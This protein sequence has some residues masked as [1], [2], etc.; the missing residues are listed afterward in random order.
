M[1]ENGIADRCLTIGGLNAEHYC[2]NEIKAV[3]GSCL[4][5]GIVIRS[6]K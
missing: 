2:G 1:F 4:G 5:I 6:I 3:R